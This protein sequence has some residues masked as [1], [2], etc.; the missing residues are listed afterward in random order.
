MRP[1]IICFLLSLVVSEFVGAK[2]T[3]HVSNTTP[4]ASIIVNVGAKKLGTMRPKAP[5]QQ[6]VF[7]CYDGENLV[8]NFDEPEGMCSMWVTDLSSN[9]T[10]QYSF[11]SSNEAIIYVGDLSNA[12]IYMV[13][14]TGAEYEGYLE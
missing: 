2:A 3:N 1:H 6:F 14:D 4:N 10:C 11:E 12:Y 5:S 8:I 9:F 7:C 13:T